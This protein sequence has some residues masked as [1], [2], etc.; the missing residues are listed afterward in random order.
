M[1]S[2]KS[3]LRLACRA[4]ELESERKLRLAG[5]DAVVAPQA[6]GAERLALMAAQPEIAQ[7]FDVVLHGSPIEFHIEELD[8]ESAVLLRVRQSRNRGFVSRVAR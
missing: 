5:A 2:L 1:K 6:V 3:D 7:I 8:V 4:T